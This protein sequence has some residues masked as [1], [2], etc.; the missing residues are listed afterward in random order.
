MIL[1]DAVRKQYERWP[2]PPP[3]GDDL[4]KLSGFLKLYEILRNFT[5]RFWPAGKPRE[6]LR[7]LVAGCGTMA[8][9]CYAY[10]YPKYRVLGIDISQAS[11]AH[12][13]KLKDRHDLKNLTLRNC[14]IEEAG[15]LGT[16]FD[17]IS[18]QGVLH[19]TSDPARALQALGGALSQD[20]I[21]RLALYGK[22]PRAPIYPM[23]E[24]FRMLGVEQ[25]PE[26]VAIVRETLAVLSPDHP[27][28]SYLRFAV[29]QHSD[30]GLVDTYLH[31]RDRA[32]SVRDCLSLVEEAGLVFQGWDM[33]FAYHPDGPLCHKPSLRQ[34]LNA[35]PDEHIWQAMETISG[36]MRMHEFHV[37]RTDRDP[38]TYRIPWESKILLEYIPARCVDLLRVQGAATQHDWAIGR[39]SWPVP[40]TLP[41][42]A[43]FSQIDGC[44][45]LREC[46]AAAGLRGSDEVLFAAAQDLIT[47]LRRTGYGLFC[48]PH[49]K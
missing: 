30:A 34:L 33:N 47:L 43:I 2:Y 26:G 40:V 41:Q 46:L 21:I 6:D 35:L 27:L 10:V 17:Y 3:H 11:L 1:N 18:C 31:R 36:T 20:G 22:H 9:A 23:Q 29:D 45:T 14:P 25:T 48:L 4:S 5:P 39:A 37:C 19:H 38:A 13:Q 32:F 49:T 16:S 42:A 7:I 28:Q 44:R 12:E 8:A 15:S 24:L